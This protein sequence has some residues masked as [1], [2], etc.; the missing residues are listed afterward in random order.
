MRGRPLGS[1]SKPKFVGVQ[2]KELCRMFNP[3]IVIPVEKDFV[4]MLNKF[5]SLSAHKI[6][7]VELESKQKVEFTINEFKT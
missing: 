5:Q 4:E 2:L 6:P 1:K 7:T 3:E